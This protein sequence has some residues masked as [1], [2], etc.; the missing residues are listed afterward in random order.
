M[1]D[2][3]PT[4]EHDE[5]ERKLAEH[6][7]A[8]V[9][10]AAARTAARMVWER[11]L[12]RVNFCLAAAVVLMCFQTGWSLVALARLKL[13]AQGAAEVVRQTLS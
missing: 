6:W 13:A 11:R 8:I 2:E 1:T 10:R 9:R 12:R 4:A 7:P 5:I 3:L